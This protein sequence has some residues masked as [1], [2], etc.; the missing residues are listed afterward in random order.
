MPTY[1]CHGFRWN[2]RAIRIYVI[3]NDLEDAASNWIIAPATSSSILNQFYDSYDFLP[4][5][6]PSTPT[7][8]SKNPTQPEG[9]HKHVDDDLSLPPSRVDPAHDGVLMHPW[10]AVKLLEEFDPE[11]TTTPCRPY[12]YVADHVIRVDLSVDVA[13]EMAKYYEKM[14]GDD[15]WIVK[16]R[17]ELQK[18]EPV[19]WYVVVCG[20]EVREVP[21]ESDND[22]DDGSS[23]YEEDEVEEARQLHGIESDSPSE[24]GDDD[25]ALTVLEDI[26]EEAELLTPRPS[27]YEEPDIDHPLQ[28]GEL[29]PQ[30]S[31]ASTASS[32]WPLQRED[33]N[34]SSRLR[35]PDINVPLL[36]DIMSSR[37]SS[38]TASGLYHDEDRLMLEPEEFALG[39]SPARTPLR[40]EAP[41][42]MM[43]IRADELVPPIS[44]SPSTPTPMKR[45]VVGSSQHPPEEFVPSRSPSPM[46]PVTS[47]REQTTPNIP[48]GPQ[49]TKPPR[50]PRPET[51]DL[52]IYE[53]MDAIYGTGQIVPPLPPPPPPPL[54]PLRSP[55]PLKSSPQHELVGSAPEDILPPQTPS[56]MSPNP[57][58]QGQGLLSSALPRP[59]D[60]TPPQTPSPKS[61]NPPQQLSDLDFEEIIPTRSPSPMSPNPP[62]QQP[63][64]PAATKPEETIPPETPSPMS[65]NPPQMEPLEPLAR[66]SEEVI[67]PRTPS[68]MSPNPPHENQPGAEVFHTPMETTPAH[69][70]TPSIPRQNQPQVSETN[71]KQESKDVVS[72]PSTNL[73]TPTLVQKET[74]GPQSPPQSRQTEVR[75]PSPM[76]PARVPQ[77]IPIPD[78]PPPPEPADTIK[79]PPPTPP[80][81]RSVQEQGMETEEKV[82]TREQH[83]VEA[84]ANISV[85]TPMAFSDEM[86]NS[87]T[88]LEDEEIVWEPPPSPVSEY[89]PGNSPERNVPPKQENMRAPPPSRVQTGQVSGPT[90][91][92]GVDKPDGGPRPPPR[93]HRRPS[94]A[95]G[96]KKLFRKGHSQKGGG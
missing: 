80:K 41:D 55:S 39:Q 86:S 24:Y 92:T 89:E 96:L 22:D 51:L 21:G 94:V 37:F 90:Q 13:G 19:R 50:P 34:L 74:P 44:P 64:G 60:V 43:P 62:Q 49:P 3:L 33:S 67:P 77:D 36:Q 47:R 38:S 65:P 9:Q 2:R 26:P 31:S 23:Y 66:K 6:A 14:A 85:S 59:E 40:E 58:Q 27:E 25:D 52:S 11:E 1:L 28:P 8:V 84:A 29:V 5:P 46:S 75:S 70:P 73:T 81:A 32:L 76:S 45:N 95:E 54:P 63:P 78:V 53:H 16:L 10:S 88:D 79:V 48:S 20:D 42:I 17:D 57:P 82:E 69:L 91:H 93:M 83:Q 4:S 35:T 15:G 87:A 61:P 68:P 30:R 7:S 12:A 18:G 72:G 71:V 56:P